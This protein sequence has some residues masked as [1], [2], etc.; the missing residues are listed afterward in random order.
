MLL[1]AAARALLVATLLAAM[2]PALAAGHVDIPAS[3][4]SFSTKP[5]PRRPLLELTPFVGG[6]LGGSFRS[7]DA[8]GET[9]RI[10]VDDDASF[11]LVVNL[12]ST[13]PTEW[14][15]VLGQQA[16]ALDRRS[17]SD[18]RPLD[19]DITYLHAGGLYLFDGEWARPYLAATLGVTRLAPEDDAFR[20]E[21]KFSFALGAGY[22]LFPA[23]R[24][25]LRL[26]ARVWGTVLDENSDLFCRAGWEAAG[27]RI[28]ARGTVLWQWELTA[29]GV[30]RF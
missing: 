15:F 5:I 2:P 24:F 13:W 18:P 26:D 14:E 16:T 11:G 22:K 4:T 9:A 29:G 12:P 6:R 20:S 27:C 21:T 23:S 3:T 1:R 10:R 19:L 25:G 8:G 17:A 28:R 7:T 30:L